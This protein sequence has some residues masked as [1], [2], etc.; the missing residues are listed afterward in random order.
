MDENEIQGIADL[1]G[2]LTDELQAQEGERWME[3]TTEGHTRRWILSSAY[4]LLRGRQ[5][6]KEN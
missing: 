3:R 4:R 1:L 5:V 6:E 2:K